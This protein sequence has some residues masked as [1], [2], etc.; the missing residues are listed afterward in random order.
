MLQNE[1]LE[2]A[3][4]FDLGTCIFYNRPIKI[5]ARDQ[6]DFIRLWVLKMHEWVLGKDGKFH[7]EPLPSSRT[8]EFIKNTRFESPDEVQSRFRCPDLY[9]FDEHDPLA[10]IGR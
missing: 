8:D 9:R 1:W 3:T 5:E 7:Y 2:R 10:R 4:I 6:P